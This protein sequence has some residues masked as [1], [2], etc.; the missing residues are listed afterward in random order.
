CSDEADR[1]MG[2]ELGADD[3]VTK[4][5][6]LRE[7]LARIRAVLRRSRIPEPRDDSV[8]AYR[9]EGWELNL[10]LFRLKTP[11]GRSI[12]I[13]RG[14]FS[15]LRAFLAS[16]QRILSRERLLELTHINSLEVYDRSIDVQIMR[17][18]RRIEPD[19]AHPRFI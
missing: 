4:P 15:L 16:P 10:R 8:R 7:L 5:F 14:E 11:D 3:Y 1:V 17:L 19:T 2:L 9:F 13:S 18:R 6:S 12:D